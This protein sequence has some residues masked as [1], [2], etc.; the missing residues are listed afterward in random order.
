GYRVTRLDLPGHGRSA[1]IEN[2]APEN[3]ATLLAE[4][5]PKSAHWIG[6][7]L[8]ATLVSYLSEGFPERVK[9]IGL[10]AGNPKFSRAPD[11]PHAIST[12]VLDQFK[13]NV[14]EDF[15]GAILRF[16][17]IQT[18]GLEYPMETYRFLK[19]RLHE[20]EAPEPRALSAGVDILKSA[21]RRAQFK[22]LAKPIRI[23]LGTEDSLV[24]V[25]VGEALIS[26]NPAIE[27]SV[28]Q[29]A[30]HIPF[31]THRERCLAEVRRFLVT[32]GANPNA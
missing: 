27:V 1:A 32:H 21:D 17:K 4:A 28:I 8:G 18:F 19:E 14:C 5:A 3:I 16:L 20:C 10:I 22:K 24:P 12:E 7:S 25:E 29:Q 15:T 6:W 26:L 23:L 13:C 9:T 30:G 2:Y 11:W 31:I